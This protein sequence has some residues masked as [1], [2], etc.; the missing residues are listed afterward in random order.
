MPEV[1]RQSYRCPYAPLGLD[2]RYI[3]VP[4]PAAYSGEPLTAC[5]GYSTSLPEVIESARLWRHWD[6]A[7]V[8]AMTG[9]DW[10]TEAATIAIEVFDDA[11]NKHRAWCA[12]NPVKKD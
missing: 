6:R 12:D 9:G 10:P 7:D 5:P 1:T 11:V 2:E 3:R 4:I 8:R